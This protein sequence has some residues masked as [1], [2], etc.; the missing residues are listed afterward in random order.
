[1]GACSSHEVKKSFVPQMSKRYSKTQPPRLSLRVSLD[2]NKDTIRSAR[3]AKTTDLFQIEGFDNC[4]LLAQ[5]A[6]SIVIQASKGGVDYA[7]KVCD[8]IESFD[9]EG[10]IYGEI[11]SD[12]LP[13]EGQNQNEFMTETDKTYSIE[14]GQTNDQN[15]SHQNSTSQRNERR[16]SIKRINGF[17]NHRP[18]VE[19][20]FLRKFDH[21]NIVKFID[22][23]EDEQ[24]RHLYIVMEY[25][26]GDNIIMNPSINLKRAFSQIL[27]AVQYLHRYRIIHQDIKPS[28]ILL[29]NFN[30]VKLIDFGT[31]I[32]IPPDLEKIPVTLSGTPHY[33]PPEFFTENECDPFAAD[34]WALGVSL[35]QIA[36]GVLP[37]QG[38]TLEEKARNI[39]S[40]ELSFPNHADKD[41]ADLISKMLMK[42][43]E[44]RIKISQIWAHPFMAK[45]NFN[46]RL[47]LQ[48]KFYSLRLKRKLQF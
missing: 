45:D 11:K 3:K 42:N 37:F 46:Q 5:G 34:V 8:Y 31:A 14:N 19:I 29:D 16:K 13:H 48:P 15:F 33:F 27:S 2:A 47:I 44:N 17:I 35:Y 12:N 43:P 25:C 30:N 7:I 20:E 28:N 9:N 39:R 26:Q 23:F 24:K 40:Q 1:M 36:F 21:P 6:S 4:R 18:K 38:K 41:L 10:E 22:S 32:S